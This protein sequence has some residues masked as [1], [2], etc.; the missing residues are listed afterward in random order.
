MRKV[1]RAF[2]ITMGLLSFAILFSAVVRAAEKDVLPD[3]PPVAL[4]VAPPNALP[5]VKVCAS[6]SCRTGH[7]TGFQLWDGY[8]LT[9]GHV[10]SG[11]KTMYLK[12]S[13]GHTQQAKVIWVSVQSDFALLFAKGWDFMGL[14]T[15]YL[16]C[17][18]PEIGAKVT[19]L[20]NP[21]PF[22]F[23]SG[24]GY[25]SGLRQDIGP[26]KKIIPLTIQSAGGSSGSPVFDDM[27][28]IMGLIVGGLRG[29]AFV[30]MEPMSKVCDILPP[31]TDNMSIT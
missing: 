4:I 10:A 16:F 30:A 27:G 14:P 17:E 7:G 6:P 24:Q 2:T 22:E 5:A 12:D 1:W 28:R 21:G 20:S 8:F 3:H 13:N 25:V 26:W 31:R 29:G 15:T 19:N 18:I 9:A 11:R 23:I